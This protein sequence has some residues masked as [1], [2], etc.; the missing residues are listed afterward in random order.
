MPGDQVKYKVNDTSVVML[1]QAHNPAIIT[2]DFL[3]KNSIAEESWELD[4]HAP[5]ISTPGAS[6]ISFKNGAQW[7]VLPDRCV[8]ME[9]MDNEFENSYLVKECAEK[10]VAV[11]KHIPYTAVGIN[12]GL[13]LVAGEDMQSWLKP[14]T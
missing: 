4:E 1:A 11:L 14:V 9:K 5:L 8:I 12:W 6:L 10:Y 2:P 13:S 7:Q 3:R